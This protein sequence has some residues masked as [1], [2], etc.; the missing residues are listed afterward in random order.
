MPD[1]PELAWLAHDLMGDYDEP[2][3]QEEDTV[4]GDEEYQTPEDDG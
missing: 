1:G 2:F 4:D 3:I